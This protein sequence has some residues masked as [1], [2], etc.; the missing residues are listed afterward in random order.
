LLTFNNAVLEITLMRTLLSILA[1]VLLVPTCLLGLGCNAKD[2]SEETARVTESIT[3]SI[4]KIISGDM[5]Q[6]EIS[7]LPLTEVG[8]SVN[9]TMFQYTDERDSVHVVHIYTFSDGEDTRTKMGTGVS[10]I[11]M[12]LT[13]NGA[14]PVGQLLFNT[15]DMGEVSKM[16]WGMDISRPFVKFCFGTSKG[17]PALIQIFSRTAEDSSKAYQRLMRLRYS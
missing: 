8:P 10:A 11:T 13:K 16:A 14:A 3:K 9:S 5:E 6:I 7:L 17:R 2:K 12:E 4:G 15:T 1:V